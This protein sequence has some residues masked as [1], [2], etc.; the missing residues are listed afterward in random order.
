[1][2]SRKRKLENPLVVSVDSLVQKVCEW[3]DACGGKY[4]VET[5]TVVGSDFVSLSIKGVDEVIANDV[6]EL[7]DQDPLIAKYTCDFTKQTL[8]FVFETH[9]R[10]IAYSPRIPEIGPCASI[11]SKQNEAI[12]KELK[13]IKPYAGLDTEEDLVTVCKCVVAVKSSLSILNIV[14]EPVTFD[15][16][17]TP[18]LVRITVQGLSKVEGKLFTTFKKLRDDF[19]AEIVLIL[20]PLSEQCIQISVKKAKATVNI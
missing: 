9:R 3:E 1:M 5:E 10:K 20:A 7:V 19:D 18:G 17:S 4:T 6:L 13:S 16:T 8:S 12:Q 2:F 14:S 15:F 11:E